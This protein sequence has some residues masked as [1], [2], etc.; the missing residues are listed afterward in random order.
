MRCEFKDLDQNGIIKNKDY[1]LKYF[2]PC[3]K[4]Q[5]HRGTCTAFATVGALEIRL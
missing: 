3:V 5:A 1:A 4:D 2:P